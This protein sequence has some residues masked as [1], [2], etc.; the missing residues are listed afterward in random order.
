MCCACKLPKIRKEREIILRFAPFPYL[1]V[2]GEKDPLLK[3]NDIIRQAKL[4]S[5][6]SFKLIE[7]SSHM[8][9]WEREE[10]VFKVVKDFLK[11]LKQ[12]AN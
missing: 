7:N 2:I 6:G 1:F 9:F 8:S 11:S 5:K 3:V 4:S 10:M 12:K